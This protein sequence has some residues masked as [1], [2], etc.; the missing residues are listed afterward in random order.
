M[1]PFQKILFPVDYS[2]CCETVV[3][4]VKDMV[5]HFR[6]DLTLVH[7]YPP[8]PI[9]YCE[10]ATADPDLMETTLAAEEQ[11]LEAYAFETFPGQHVERFAELGEPGSVIGRIIHR[12]RTDLVMLATNGRGPI[13]RFL[14]G[15]VAAKV[16]HDVDTAVWTGTGAS[17]HE[18]APQIPYRSVL[19]AVDD[20]AEA[21][22][23]VLA[24]GALACDYKAQLSL[25]HVVEIPPATIE[26]DFA[27]YAQN[28][29]DAADFHLRELKAKLGIK[30]PHTVID[31]PV[32]QGIHDEAIRRKADLIVLGR[33]RAHGGFS[34]M[35]SHLYPIIRKSPCPVLS[36]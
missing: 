36:I 31:S 20:N 34:R 9:A 17:L 28:L 35:W 33:G 32:P 22:G 27:P 24:A 25:V 26:V 29:R 23:V 30:V 16:L 6:A 14:L 7:A 4:Y 18:H 5:R 19:C 11:R 10:F 3:P 2:A 8:A 1:I 13:R 15:S 21:E 12:Q